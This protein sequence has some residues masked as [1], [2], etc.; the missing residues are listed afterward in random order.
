M[1]T[2]SATLRHRHL[3]ASAAHLCDY[4][5][6]R[7]ADP[8]DAALMGRQISDALNVSDC[9]QV[10]CSNGAPIALYDNRLAGPTIAIP[11]VIGVALLLCL[12]LSYRL[13]SE[14]NWTQFKFVTDRSPRI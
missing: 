8:E 9:L 1:L 2:G 10:V 12:G 5:A 7:T 3:L 14:F 6:L 11:C 13:T 4:A